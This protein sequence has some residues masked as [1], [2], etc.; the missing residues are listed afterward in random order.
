MPRRSTRRSAYALEQ[1]HWGEDMLRHQERP[2][3]G[4]EAQDKL[5]KGWHGGGEVLGV[6]TRRS[7]LFVAGSAHS[8][9]THH[10]G[11]R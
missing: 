4:P 3:R 10:R 11:G 6:G 7:V 8:L 2:Q 5:R 1:L 9:G